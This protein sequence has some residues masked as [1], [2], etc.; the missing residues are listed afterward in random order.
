MTLKPKTMI[1]GRMLPCTRLS[2]GPVI[3]VKRG[4]IGGL[5]CRGRSLIFVGGITENVGLKFRLVSGS[6]TCNSDRLMEV[7]VLGSGHEERRLFLAAEIDGATRQ[8]REMESRFFSALG[9]FS[10]GC[11]SLLRFR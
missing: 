8:R 1:Q 5:V 11:I 4:I 2:S 6:T 10:A 7:T 3:G 9:T